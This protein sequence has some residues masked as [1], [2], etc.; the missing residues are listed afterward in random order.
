MRERSESGVHHDVLRD[1]STSIS[2]ACREA[3]DGTYQPGASFTVTSLFDV[4]RRQK[5]VRRR[6]TGN[7]EDMALLYEEIWL[8]GPSSAMTLGHKKERIIALLLADAGARP[9]DI[10]RLYRTFEGWQTQMDFYDKG[11]RVRFFYPKEVVPGSSRNNATGYYFSSWVDIRNTSPPA[12]STPECLRDFIN[13]SSSDEFATSHIPELDAE[14][15]PL[16]YGKKSSGRFQ[17]AS[18]DHI[19]NVAK[20]TLREAGMHSMT[21]RSIRGASP[22]K[23]VQLFPDLLP[24]ALKLGRWTNPRTFVNHYQGK[25]NLVSTRTPPTAIKDNL[26]QILRWGFQPRPPPHVSAT[27]YMLGPNHWLRRTVPNL[28]RVEAF[29]KGVYTIISKGASKELYHYELMA[30]ISAARDSAT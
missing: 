24:H 9:S 13:D 15:Q 3:S 26:Q 17:P 16:L 27:E 7:Y 1:I 2:T 4:L 28:G 22:S 11:V 5:P 6:G 8:Y 25:V 19:S 20:A 30:A 14:T 18:V 29:D 23:I 10:A 12:I 21:T